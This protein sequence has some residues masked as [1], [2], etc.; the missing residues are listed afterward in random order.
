MVAGC[1]EWDISN[2]PLRCQIS[3]RL[4]P[5]PPPSPHRPLHISLT[6]THTQ[7]LLTALSKQHPR[8]AVPLLWDCVRG[9][10]C[11]LRNELLI[12]TTGSQEYYNAHNRRR[13]RC[14]RAPPPS[15]RLHL[16]G[17]GTRPALPVAR[18]K[19]WATSFPRRTRRLKARGRWGE[20][21]GDGGV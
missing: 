1:R 20:G 21:E 11:D 14:A 10:L 16:L 8:T 2:L 9:Q 19:P 4:D 3:G 13:G 5:Q 6:Y 17:R 12:R 7:T 15:A 18:K